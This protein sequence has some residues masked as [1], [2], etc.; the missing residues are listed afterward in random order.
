M[1]ESG[2]G[3]AV[4]GRVAAKTNPEFKCRKAA[5]FSVIL[6]ISGENRPFLTKKSAIFR[7]LLFTVMV[8]VIL[9]R[10]EF[11][12]LKNLRHG[13]SRGI[14]WGVGVQV[15]GPFPASETHSSPMRGVDV[16]GFCEEK[17]W[18][19]WGHKNVVPPTA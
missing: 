12:L 7:A 17:E 2:S 4:A 14:F 16:G 13:K 5:I 11:T 6:P 10:T 8:I 18:W 1:P 15:F 19:P 9:Y 3:A